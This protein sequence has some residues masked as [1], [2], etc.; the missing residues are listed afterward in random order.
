MSLINKINFQYKFRVL[1][2]L[3]DL[4]KYDEFFKELK[5]IENNQKNFL[6]L[7]KAFVSAI[8]KDNENDIFSS[9]IVWLNSFIL[10]D[11]SYLNKFIIYYMGQ[12]Q[13]NID[14]IKTYEEEIAE[15]F[16]D[17]ELKKITF[18]D[19]L[20]NSY[21][22]QWLILQNSIR[23]CIFINN[24][25]PFFS[26]KNNYNFTKVTLTNCFISI[27]DHPYNIYQ[28]IKN[29]NDNDIE[30]SRN[31][32][33]NLDNRSIFFGL[34]NLTIEINRQG[35]H[36]NL[37][38]W[39]D[40]NVLNSLR[41]KIIYKSDL[42]NN[43]YETLSSVI[44]HL[45]QSGIKIEIDYEIIQKFVSSNPAPSKKMEHNISLKEKKFLAS[46]IDNILTDMD[47]ENLS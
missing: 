28:T 47:Q 41:G 44:F 11:L 10:D 5:K 27:V 6:D 30:K 19:H 31:I 38:S 3:F 9:K 18:E 17:K 26:T 23:E 20:D 12:Q 25:M 2:E 32:F 24:Q 7:S 43:T 29:Q 15:V 46:Y 34:K 36:T 16:K 13:K 4:K 35:W 40:P 39:K 14:Q 8:I 22:Y 37:S 33:L 45:I 1:K 42:I 21:L